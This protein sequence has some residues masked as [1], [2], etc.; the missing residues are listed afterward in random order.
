MKSKYQA[1]LAWIVLAILRYNATEWLRVAS[2]NLPKL[3]IGLLLLHLYL[4]K[5][6]TSFP[7]SK[8]YLRILTRYLDVD[9]QLSLWKLW[10]LMR[11]L[12]SLPYVMDS[13]T[14]Y[15]IVIYL[16]KLGVWPSSHS[17]LSFQFLDAL[18]RHLSVTT[19]LKP[20]SSL[21]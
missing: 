18:P 9:Q 21:S 7:K 5:T 3:L 19:F 20:I 16:S 8:L 15:S 17:E 11:Y 6:L 14:W 4:F 2:L 10:R 1:I 13:M 12:L